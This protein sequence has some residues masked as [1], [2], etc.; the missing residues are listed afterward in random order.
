MR[1]TKHTLSLRLPPKLLD[2]IPRGTQ[3][4]REIVIL[5]L[6]QWRV[7][8]ALEKYRRGEC[9][10]AFAAQDAGITL[11]EIVPLAYAFGLEPAIDPHLLDHDF[12]PDEATRL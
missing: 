11:R 1:A 5:G 12:T 7:R 3:A 10:L 6:R 4:Q 8:K 9:T 2:Q